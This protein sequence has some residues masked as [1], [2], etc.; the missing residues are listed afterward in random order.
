MNILLIN[1]WITDFAA[2]DFWVKPLGLLYAGAFLKQRG[3]DVRLLDCMDRFQESAVADGKYFN[4]RYNTGKFHREI[5]KKPECLKHVPRHFCRYGIPVDLFRKKIKD[6]RKPDIVLVSCIM[7][8]WYPG[9]FNVI[10]LIHKMLPGVP[11]LL[12][13]IYATLCEDHARNNSDSNVVTNCSVPSTIIETVEAAGGS[14]GDGPLVP[15]NF[16]EWPEPAW[17]LY[18]N[19]KTV[20][21]LTTRG[22]PMNCTV[23][24]SKILFDGFERRDP[25]KAAQEIIGLAEKGVQ[26][27]SFCDDALLVDTKNHTVPM[28]K[29]LAVSKTPVR[30]HTPNGLHIR[31]ITPEIARL[32]K[33]AGIVTVRL[34]LE[35]ASDERAKDFSYKVSREDFKNAVDALY[36]AGYTPDDLG[37]YTI[38]GLPGQN[39]E[40][41]LDTIEFVL[42][43]GVKVRPALFSPVPGTV[44]FRR[45]IEAGMIKEDDDP[46]L[47][48]NTLRTFDLW[49]GGQ[50]GYREFKK[51]LTEAN[52]GVGKRKS[53][54]S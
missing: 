22:C 29:R 35:T 48:N 42:D 30:L 50:E 23:C 13:G 19:L 33:R 11:V 36:S 41:V 34:S 47:H 43:T 49:E 18:D 53:I 40:E 54:F 26:D 5:I 21:V 1:P 25:V 8:Y 51:W 12:G 10:S 24:A 17:E 46:L 45:A 3:H 52:E 7:T 6:V 15:D 44:E 39:M 16:S 32:M 2:Y 27:I 37:A 31:E 9:A 20:T 38:A 4:R 28:F 14:K